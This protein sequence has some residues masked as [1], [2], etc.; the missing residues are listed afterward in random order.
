MAAPLTTAFSPARV[1]LRPPGVF[2]MSRSVSRVT[3]TPMSRTE[4]VRSDG[5][6]SRK[7]TCQ[8]RSP[9]S[10]RGTRRQLLTWRAACGGEAICERQRPDKT[11]ERTPTVLSVAASHRSRPGEAGP[12]RS[13]VSSNRAPHVSGFPS[14]PSCA[15]WFML[16]A[17]HLTDVIR[18]TRSHHLPFVVGALGKRFCPWQAPFSE[19]FY[20]AIS[21]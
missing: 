18:Q 9:R 7:G 2:S 16:L 14:C 12:A 19:R 15:S 11:D 10:S 21:P 6:L 20:F 13:A 1:S 8:E 5:R 3:I 17:R 4:S